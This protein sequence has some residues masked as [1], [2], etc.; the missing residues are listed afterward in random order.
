MTF[1]NEEIRN[2][3][4]ALPAQKQYEWTHIE[5][6]LARTGKVLHITNVEFDKTEGTLKVSIHVY[7]KLNY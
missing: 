4:H 6:T 5:D 3:F 1:E 7:D 2:V